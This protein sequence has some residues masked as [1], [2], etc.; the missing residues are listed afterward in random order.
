MRENFSPA[1]YAKVCHRG[2]GAAGVGGTVVGLADS[3]Q[4][5]EIYSPQVLAA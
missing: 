1:T 5:I 2:D 3:Q 4:W